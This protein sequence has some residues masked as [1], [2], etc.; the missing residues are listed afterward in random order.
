M[1]ENPFIQFVYVVDVNSGK[2]TTPN[3]AHVEDRA[4]YEKAGMDFDYSDRPWFQ[5]P[6]KSGKV[7]VSDF[8]TSR[9]T[10]RLCITVAAP[11]RNKKDDIVAVLGADL[12]FEQLVKYDEMMEKKKI[13]GEELGKGE[14]E[15]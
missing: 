1:D 15:S 12:M 7:F 14:E 2:K 11:I 10:N 9:I 5:R 6:I 4:L 8:Y 13:D 3:I